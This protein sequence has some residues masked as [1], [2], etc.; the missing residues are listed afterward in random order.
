MIYANVLNRPPDNQGFEYGLGLLNDGQL[1]RGGV[2]RW[3]AANPEFRN[4]HLYGGK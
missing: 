1:N 2:V 4:N 3:I